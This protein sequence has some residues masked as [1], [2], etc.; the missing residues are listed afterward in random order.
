MILKFDSIVEGGEG[1]GIYGY[2]YYSR[3]LFDFRID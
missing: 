1:N 2:V 3:V